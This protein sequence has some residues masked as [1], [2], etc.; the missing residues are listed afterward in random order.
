LPPTK[1]LASGGQQDRDGEDGP[2]QGRR[3]SVDLTLDVASNEFTEAPPKARFQPVQA[4]PARTYADEAQARRPKIVVPVSTLP[5]AGNVERMPQLSAKDRI[6][7]LPSQGRREKLRPQQRGP[8]IP[9]GARPF[10]V[11][12]LLIL[13]FSGML[14]ATHKYVT[15]RWNPFAGISQLS[16][17]FV[18]G[19]EGVTTTDV[20]LRPDAST[21]NPSI[22]LAENGSRVKILSA[23][24]HWFEVQILEH[25][26]PKTDPFTSDRGWIARR[27][28]KF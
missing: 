6:A 4:A 28:V 2:H 17:I 9:R 5:K 26:R 20:R 11:A 7:A 22:G 24:E 19:S 16:D 10:L 25:G 8:A 13:A 3:P 1:P 15:S 12:A 27:F 21:A 18:V 23:T 14:L